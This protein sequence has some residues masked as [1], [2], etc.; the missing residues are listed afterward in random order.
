MLSSLVL[1]SERHLL[2]YQGL[3][4]IRTLV[5]LA[6]HKGWVLHQLDVKSAF[7]NGVLNEEVYIE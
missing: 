1:I 3:I 6:A 5:A 7:L 2:R 4:Q